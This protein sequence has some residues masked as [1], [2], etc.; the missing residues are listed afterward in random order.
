MKFD[1]VPDVESVKWVFKYD[2]EKS[3]KQAYNFFVN[4]AETATYTGKITVELKKHKVIIK[5]SRSIALSLFE[6]SRII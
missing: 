1:F 5:G 4:E 6:N 2:N 3:A